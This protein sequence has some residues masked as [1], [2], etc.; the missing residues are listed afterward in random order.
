MKRLPFATCTVENRGSTTGPVEKARSPLSVY[1]GLAITCFSTQPP[2][3]ETLQRAKRKNWPHVLLQVTAVVRMGEAVVALLSLERICPRRS[4]RRQNG[5]PRP[6]S[7]CG[8]PRLRAGCRLG[9]GP[10]CPVPFAARRGK[11][12]DGVA[13]TKRFPGKPSAAVETASDP[14]ER[15]EGERH[16]TDLHLPY[17]NG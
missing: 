3:A 17:T 1:I 7:L 12:T 9:P 2:A 6:P 13:H 14:G 8:L 11:S 4:Q 10:A 15:R 16:V 5:L